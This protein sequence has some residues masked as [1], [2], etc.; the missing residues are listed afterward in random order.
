VNITGGTLTC[1]TDM[2]DGGGNATSIL[3]LNGGTLDLTGHN[4]GGATAIDTLNFQSGTLANVGEINSGGALN[5]TTTGTLVITGANLYSGPTAI[6]NGTLLVN[7]TVSGAGQFTLVAGT[8]GGGGSI[9]GT[10][11][12]NGGSVAPGASI[13]KLTVL[14]DFVQ[15]GGSLDVQIG[16]PAPVTGY[17]VLD[18]GGAAGISGTL[19]VT[20]NGYAPAAGDTFTILTATNGILGTFAATSLPPL[21][22]PD[23]GWNLQYLPNAVV[24]SVT[25]APPPATGYDAYALQI[26]NTAL[27]GL[28][29]DADGDGYANLL[30]YVTG[31]N[32][33]SADNIARMNGA[34]TNGVLA[35]KFTRD[36]N[37][38]DATLYVEG[39]Y[40]ATN[41]AAWLGVAIN[42]N[43]V[44][45]SGAAVETGGPNP[46][47]VTVQ[48]TDPAATNRFLR[49]RVTRP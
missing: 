21:S 2:V 1:N 40:G 44:W 42:S 22:P 25:G 11:V 32:P 20:T 9:A 35:L 37:T 49:L 19:N 4:L 24:L 38:V 26:T 39:S 28:T 14:S 47:S 33:T 16:G 5:K 13:G 45:T 12:Q 23:I 30:E 7:G 6:S 48:D 46:V 34:R 17:D 31:G 8:L 18:V 29:A 10:V 36:T 15:N 41:N 43:G 3:T 27:R